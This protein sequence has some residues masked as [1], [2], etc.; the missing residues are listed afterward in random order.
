MSNSYYLAKTANRPAGRD[1]YIFLWKGMISSLTGRD[2]DCRRGAAGAC[3]LG[4]QRPCVRSH[5]CA[6]VPS[7][8]QKG[9]RRHARLNLFV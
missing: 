1:A 3:E 4:S 6:A 5:R 9:T 7:P 2:L 8:L